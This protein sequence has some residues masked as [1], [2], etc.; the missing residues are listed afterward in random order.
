MGFLII[1]KLI[2]AIQIDTTLRPAMRGQGESMP[3][4]CDQS[5]P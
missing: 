1:S 4:L 3:T 5:V 2:K